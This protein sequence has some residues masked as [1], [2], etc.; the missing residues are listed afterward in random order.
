MRGYFI[1]VEGGEG[2]GKTTV[3]DMIYNRLSDLGYDVLITREP[4]GIPISEEIREVILNPVNTEM[5][6]R[7][8]A[9]LYA[10]AR[11]QHL[12]EKVI[13]AI[14][15]G[16]IVLCDRFIDS[17]IAY[18]GYARG[19][20]MDEVMTINTFAT[21]NFLPSLTLLFDIKPEVGLARIDLN[22][23]REKNRLDLEDMSFHHKVY[24]GYEQLINKYPERI[25]RIN[26]ESTIE[27]VAEDAFNLII[28]HLH[29][30]EEE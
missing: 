20:G 15:K 28:K 24:E 10:A 7:T 18:Q 30:N 1:T 9:L 3:L 2:S 6:E 29:E 5:E 13:P 14:N 22:N 26:A 17:S 25:K 23:Q 11:R 21:N 16:K 27:V 8:E 12:V 19:I 4:G